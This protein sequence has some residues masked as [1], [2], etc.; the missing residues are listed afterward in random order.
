[1]AKRH[2]RI[3]YGS[4]TGFNEGWREEVRGSAGVQV[5]EMGSDGDT[6]MLLAF[7]LK[8][9]VGEMSEG[10]VCGRLVGFGEPALMCRGGSLCHGE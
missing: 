4:L 9:S 2:E 8:G 10:E 6:E 1:V 7:V 5:E 3:E